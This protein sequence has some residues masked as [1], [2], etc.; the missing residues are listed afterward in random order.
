[1]RMQ[2][3]EH[4]AQNTRGARCKAHAQ[5]RAHAQSILRSEQTHREARDTAT[6]AAQCRT[7]AEHTRRAHAERKRSTHTQYTHAE[8]TH[9]V[10]TQK[11]S[12]HIELTRAAL[13]QSTHAEQTRGKTLAEYTRRADA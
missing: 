3:T 13:L 6:S 2:S 1:M 5:R 9:I 4:R 11:K 8:N 10:H 12:K 7:V